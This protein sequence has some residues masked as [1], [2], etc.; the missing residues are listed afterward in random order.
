VSTSED[1]LRRLAAGDERSLRTT[2]ALDAG[3]AG[4][5]LDRRSVALVRL[6][7]L[8]AVGACVT[9]LRWAAELAGAAGVD[10]AAIAAAFVATGSAVGEARIVAGARAL[11]LALD[12]DPTA[13][14]ATDPGA[15]RL[16]PAPPPRTATPPRASG[17]PRAPGP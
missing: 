11:A 5:G 14:A 15:P 12:I 9:S 2:L 10:D 7:A 13:D 16:T 6:A 1:L 4:A 17:R 3:A 8:L